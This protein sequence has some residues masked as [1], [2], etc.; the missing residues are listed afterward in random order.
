MLEA[1]QRESECVAV[2]AASGNGKGKADSAD[3]ADSAGG[4]D[5][6]EPADAVAATDSSI[7][8]VREKTAALCDDDRQHWNIQAERLVRQYTRIVVMPQNEKHLVTEIKAAT[9]A[10]QLVT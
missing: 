10:K 9:S 2:A 3:A 1:L 6:G 7:K 5:V 4:G 8:K